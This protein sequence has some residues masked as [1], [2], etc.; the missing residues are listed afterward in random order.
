MV[1]ALEQRVGGDLVSIETEEEWNFINDE[2]QRRNTTNYDNKWSIGLTKKRPGIG[3]GWVEERWLFANGE[4]GIC[5]WGKGKPRGEYRGLSYTSSSIMANG[6]C[7]VVIIVQFW[8]Q[9]IWFPRESLFL[10]RLF[11]LLLLLLLL[12]LQ[13]LVNLKVPEVLR[14]N[15]DILCWRLWYSRRNLYKPSDSQD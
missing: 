6:A 11:V 10:F 9:L 12:L 8:E 15:K 14:R 2:I 7:L 13:F 3:A 4:K 5:K 1:L